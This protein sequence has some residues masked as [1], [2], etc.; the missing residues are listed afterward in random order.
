MEMHF[1]GNKECSLNFHTFTKKKN[2]LYSANLFFK[3]HD[4][5]T[6]EESLCSPNFM[7]YCYKKVNFFNSSII[8]K[9]IAMSF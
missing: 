8:C 7:Y 5:R 9:S 4:K 1:E 2:S 6:C 3:A